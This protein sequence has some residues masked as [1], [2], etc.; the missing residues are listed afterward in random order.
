MQ[1]IE[2]SFHLHPQACPTADNIHGYHWEQCLWFS[3]G[4][5]EFLS[6]T[7]DFCRDESSQCYISIENHA[8]HQKIPQDIIE[9]SFMVFYRKVDFLS[10]TLNFYRAEPSECNIFIEN[11]FICIDKHARHQTIRKDIIEN[12]FTI[13]YRKNW[14]SIGNIEFLSG[15][16]LRIW[17]FL[18]GIY[19]QSYLTPHDI[20]ESHR[21]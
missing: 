15:P 18:S 19:H 13:F 7:L 2:K 8:R 10:E 14:I 4:N 11:H 3:I 21:E 9:Y 1:F 6:G 20:T 5:F 12:I 17:L 16:T